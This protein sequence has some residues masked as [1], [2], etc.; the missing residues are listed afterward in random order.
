MRKEFKYLYL[1]SYQDSIDIEDIG[2]C[3]LEAFNDDGL[4]FYLWIKTIDGI[5]KILEAGP[6]DSDDETNP[7]KFITDI[8][9]KQFQFSDNKINEII[10][11]FLNNIIYKITQVFDKNSEYEDTDKLNKI[12]NIVN[13]MTTK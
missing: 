6:Y 5:T 3:F 11:K 2:N 10:N 7:T 1:A 8:K 13:Y 9:Y 4:C 12:Y